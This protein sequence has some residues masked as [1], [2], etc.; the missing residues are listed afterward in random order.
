MET[1]NIE[2]VDTDYARNLLKSNT[3]NRPINQTNLKMLVSEM[4]NGNF[5]FNG[6]TITITSDGKIIDGQHRLLALIES[7]YSGNFIFVRGVAESAFSTKDN[8]KK[9]SIQDVLYISGEVNCS[10]LA[11][12]LKAIISWEINKEFY[13][14]ESF[15]VESFFTALEN[16]PKVKYYVSWFSSG[17]S[18]LNKVGCLSAMAGVCTIFNTKYSQEKIEE[19]LLQVGHGENIAKGMPAY[20]FRERLQLSTRTQRIS[21]QIRIA[22]FA[23]SLLAHCENKKMIICKVAENDSLKFDI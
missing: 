15:S 17:S 2:Y 16:Y 4:K 3:I 20:A 18:M 6:D 1:V 23:K 19:F 10:R 11:S 5:V 22:M 9:R 8:G 7:G 21:Q 13:S 14:G 12:A